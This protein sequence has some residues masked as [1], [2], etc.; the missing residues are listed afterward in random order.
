VCL[1]VVSRL[2]LK[3]H[4]GICPGIKLP[5]PAG[6]LLGCGSMFLER[7]NRVHVLTEK[8]NKF[9]NTADAD[10][11]TVVLKEHSRQFWKEAALSPQVNPS[12]HA[13]NI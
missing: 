4:L 7:H 9:S 10:R 11:I 8:I 5:K 1:L 12:S 13:I 3:T 2:Q 6:A